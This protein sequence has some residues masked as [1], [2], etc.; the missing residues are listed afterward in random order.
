MSREKSGLGSFL[1]GSLV[2]AALGILFAPRPGS[3]TRLLLR[4]KAQA[5]LDNAD[6][7]NDSVRDRAV[8]LYSVASGRAGEATG[9]LKEKIDSAR[10]RLTETVNAAAD[11]A[12][13]VLTSV[14]T[15]AADSIAVKDKGESEDEAAADDAA[16]TDAG[17]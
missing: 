2:G 1:F 3:E 11:S 10:V 12:A 14:K 7:I 8:E 15:A 4:E 6:V 5:Y 16:S 13:Q 17:A 9:Q